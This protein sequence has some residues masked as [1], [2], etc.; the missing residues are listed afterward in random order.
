MMDMT[1]E[2]GISMTLPLALIP[3]S[4]YQKIFIAPPHRIKM[5]TIAHRN[6][7][8]EFRADRGFSFNRMS[9]KSMVTCPSCF[10]TQAADQ[11]PMAAMRYSVICSTPMIGR[12]RKYRVKTLTAMRATITAV[13]KHAQKPKKSII[14][15]RINP[16]FF[17]NDDSCYPLSIKSCSRQ[18]PSK[19]HIFSTNPEMS[20]RGKAEED[21][22]PGHIDSR[23]EW[24]E[25]GEFPQ[26][27]AVHRV[28]F[29]NIGP[30]KIQESIY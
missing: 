10:N 27:W 24:W 12:F 14:L 15:S 19:G 26:L 8:A 23:F 30:C 1:I 16:A 13:R 2:S 5:H 22:P 11:K 6:E 17:S 28:S 7:V 9:T 21:P 29:N 20:G 18:S 4:Q 25:P 3:L